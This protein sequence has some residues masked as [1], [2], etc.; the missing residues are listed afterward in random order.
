MHTNRPLHLWQ[1]H[2]RDT[3]S[4]TTAAPEAVADGSEEEDGEESVRTAGSL[5]LQELATP[6]PHRKAVTTK[7][8]STVC[9]GKV[10]S[11]STMVH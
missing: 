8:A 1:A 3:A 4:Q 10:L 9:I 2:T 7:E 11:L 5:Q 6:T